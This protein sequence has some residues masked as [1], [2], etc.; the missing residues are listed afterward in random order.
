VSRISGRTAAVALGVLSAAAVGFV[1]VLVL[2]GREDAHAAAPLP[3]H[4][5]ATA[6]APDATRIED[7]S[8]Q[9]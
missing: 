7:C 6:F 1:A 4:P 8:D 9:R 5:V 2:A 3:L